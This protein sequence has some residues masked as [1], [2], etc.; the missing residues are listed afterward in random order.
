MPFLSTGGL[1]ISARPL[2]LALL[3]ARKE[4]GWQVKRLVDLRATILGGE[5][6]GS[7]VLWEKSW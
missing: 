7:P 4:T 2:S 1:G 5:R 3:P 6:A